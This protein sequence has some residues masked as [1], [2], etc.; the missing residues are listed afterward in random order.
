M[1]GDT[2]LAALEGLRKNGWTTGTRHDE[3]GKMCAIG[4]FEH[5]HGE[6]GHW[7]ADMQADSLAALEVLAAQVSAD[8][9]P[10]PSLG[11]E[12]VCM[13]IV[14]QYNNSRQSFAEIEEW[15]EKAALNEGVSL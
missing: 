9:V 2:I 4:A 14:A 13:G 10:R 5:L 7:L 3:G 1:I 8:F 15:F 11:C 12:P 6:Q